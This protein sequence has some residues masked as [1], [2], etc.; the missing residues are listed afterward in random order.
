ME[1]DGGLHHQE[2]NSAGGSSPETAKA[3]WEKVK[4][5]LKE[6]LSDDA[7]SRWFKNAELVDGDERG[8]AV[9][10]VKSD[11]Q[12]IWIETNYMDELRAAFAEGAGIHS[13]AV[14]TVLGEEPAAA[15]KKVARGSAGASEQIRVIKPD[16]ESPMTVALERKLKRMGIN[17]EFDFESFVVGDNSQFA[18]AACS[19]VASREG[20]SFN[21]LFIH[22]RAGL[23]KTHLMSA[24]AQQLLIS[25]PKAK[26]VF[27]TA[28][29]FA[30]EFI[31]A[32]RKGSLDAFRKSY[33]S[34]DVMLVDDIQFIAGKERTQ[35][36]FFHTFSA[37][38][39]TQTQLV[40]TCDRPAHEIQQLEPRLVSRFESGLTVELETPGFETRVAILQRKMDQWN[41]NLEDEVIFHIAKLIQ[42][43]VRR[44]E[45]ALTRVASFSFL[46]SE[47]MTIAKVDDLLRDLIR[48][49][50]SRQIT[51]D[52]IQKAVCDQYDLS[53]A[54]MS[55]RRRPASIAF[56]RQIA[57]ALSRQLTSLSLVEIGEAFGRRDHGTVIHACKRVEQEI[58]VNS[59]VKAVV[60]K[61]IAVLQR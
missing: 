56:P 34:A 27:L 46:S 51:V 23:G 36:E 30:N 39:N 11:M 22:G 49:E 53:L 60:E 20:R 47:E 18:H 19:A 4:A 17:P 8:A 29:Q 6:Y 59:E 32:V 16:E 28:E 54:D 3:V 10:A 14:V 43:N 38:L 12:Q 57:M 35:D 9:V 21:P 50:N 15:V 13:K 42:S 41:V 25:D 40:L 61:L 45:G 44:L 26:V 7:F 31:D 58:E 48:D 33:R 24:I 1:Q 37:L 55:S 52:A 5:K 2:E